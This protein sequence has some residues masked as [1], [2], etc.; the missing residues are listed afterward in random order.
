MSYKVITSKCVIE[1]SEQV[2]KKVGEGLATAI[3]T[4]EKATEQTKK[5]L[6]KQ[7][8]PI[9]TVG[10][11]TMCQEQQLNTQ[12][13]RPRGRKRVQIEW[14]IKSRR[15]AMTYELTILPVKGSNV[16]FQV[17]SEVKEAGKNARKDL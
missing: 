8:S 6:G 11:T 5:T 13:E 3:E 14:H 17:I 10:D 7:T 16:Q 15:R 9:P 1:S 12:R 4:G 2:N